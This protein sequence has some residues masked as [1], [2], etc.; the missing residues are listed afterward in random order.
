MFDQKSDLNFTRAANLTVGAN[1]QNSALI[2]MKGWSALTVLVETETI[3]AAGAGIAFKLQHSN[4]TATGTFED[5][6]AAEVIGSALPVTLDT[7]DNLL[8]GT[9]G[10]R[11]NRRYV[12]LVATGGA[13]TN[14]VVH[15]VYVRGRATTSSP[16]ASI[17][18]TTAAT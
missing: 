2:D 16:V 17:G 12:R 3:T 11:G 14:G 10:Y 5:C 18:T 15:A 8:M 9:I 7:D 13:S 1:T 4:S 6:T